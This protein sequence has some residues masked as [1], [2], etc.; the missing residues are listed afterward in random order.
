[1]E[2]LFT[3]LDQHLDAAEFDVEAL[4]KETATRPRRQKEPICTAIKALAYST[5][6]DLIAS[7]AGLRP[8]C[9]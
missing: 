5:N 1:M 3:L 2:G 7:P 8:E 9:R 4:A 6:G